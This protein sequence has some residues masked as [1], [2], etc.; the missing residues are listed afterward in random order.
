MK[1]DGNMFNTINIAS[2]GLRAY[3]R[4]I[5]MISSNITN[6]QTTDAGNGQPYRRLVAEFKAAEIKDG[7]G[8]VE[9][10]D[11]KQDPSDF[12]MILDP[13]HP[14]A[15]ANGYVAMPNV[16]L[17]REMIDLNFAS[18]AYQANASILKRYQK[19]METSLELLR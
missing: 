1:I 18:K 17:A 9:L 13:G 6:I 12:Q 5:E 4:K 15:D 10:G 7:L 14:N 2:S 11:I 8:G 3:N 19:M 16:N